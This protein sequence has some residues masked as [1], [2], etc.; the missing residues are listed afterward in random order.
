MTL[1][2]IT[3]YSQDTISL[4][5]EV[6]DLYNNNG[7]VQYS[8]YNKDKSIPDENYI[9][10]YKQSISTITNNTSKTTFKNLPVG[11]YAVNIL[12]DENEDGKIKKGWVL[13]IEGIGF[14]NLNNI[15]LFNRPSFER[16]KFKLTDNKNIT[17]KI[18]YL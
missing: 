12:H 14:S 8:L 16:T 1:K 11:E 6:S 7:V 18:I 5:I 2:A 3:T 17:I 9:N 4:T 10:Y 15:N 13:P